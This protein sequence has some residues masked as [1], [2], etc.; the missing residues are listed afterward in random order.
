MR[1]QGISA[2]ILLAA[3]ATATGIRAEIAISANDG[4]F[5][6]VNG[7]VQVIKD[8][9]ADTITIV[10]FAASPPK[11]IAEI[12]VPTSVVGPPLNVAISNDESIALIGSA[13]KLDP[14]DPTKTVP[15]DRISVVDLKANPPAVI[16]TLTAGKG[17]AG[18]SINRAG[19]LALAANRGEGTV[20]I[21]TISGK[22]VAVVGK[23]D[24]G[25][26]SS[27]PSHVVF[28]AD[29]KT[30]FVS[31]DNDHKVSVLSI[32]GTKVEYTKRD[33]HAGLRPYGIDMRGGTMLVVANIGPGTGDADTISLIDT[34]L[35]P[36]RVVNTVSV[37]QTPEGIKMSNDGKFVAVTYMNGS[38][39]APNS[40][41][42]NKDGKIAI[43]AINGR[44]LAKVAEASL[45]TWCQGV[46]WSKDNKSLLAQCMVEQELTSFSFDGKALTKTGTIK[47][48]GG[49]AGIRTA[50]H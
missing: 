30:A 40:P 13:M 14:A 41:F 34:A 43:Y 36:P 26:A 46:V 9:P 23:V 6:L 47:I 50:E 19:N 35:N 24:L 38:N 20:S 42:Y 49:G 2:A 17:V 18:L 29:G 27:G 22:N 15:D 12:N 7:A 39:K 11:A 25:V 45:G 31:R 21:L 33:M 48:K 3:M 44:E 5:R 10:D 4:K 1:K 32:E 28:S 8:P 37:G 16:A